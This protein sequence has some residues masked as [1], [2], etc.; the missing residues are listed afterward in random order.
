M[1]TIQEIEDTILTLPPGQFY[2]LMDWMCHRHLDVLTSDG[3]ESP[4]LEQELLG[5]LG[6]EA[7][8][9]NEALFARLRKNI[10]SKVGGGQ[11]S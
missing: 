5:A 6:E 3:F 4:E 10:E 2:E 9:A 8:P 1:A 7:V 11:A